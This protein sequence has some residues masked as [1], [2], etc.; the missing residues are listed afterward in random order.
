MAL[1]RLARWTCWRVCRIMRRLV[2]ELPELLTVAGVAA[3]CDVSRQTVRT[4][5]QDGYVQPVARYW[6]GRRW[7]LLFDPSDLRGKGD[8]RLKPAARS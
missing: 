3:Y 5:V 8:R 7:G 2:A 6:T 4:W 1:R